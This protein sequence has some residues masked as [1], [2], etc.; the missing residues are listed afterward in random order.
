MDG[1][2]EFAF[3]ARLRAIAALERSRSV[4]IVR[5]GLESP[6]YK[7]NP[8]FGTRREM[9]L[10]PNP[11]NTSDLDQL[12]GMTIDLSADDCVVTGFNAV[13]EPEGGSNPTLAKKHRDAMIRYGLPPLEAAIAQEVVDG[14]AELERRVNL[15]WKLKYPQW[16]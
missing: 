1:Y 9:K 7:Y 12:G 5:R 11:L 14:Y 3:L 2:A 6:Y 16:S 13:G 15:G 4:A 10:N 8:A